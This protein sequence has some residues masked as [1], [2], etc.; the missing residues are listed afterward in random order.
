M[1]LFSNIKLKANL[2]KANP[3]VFLELKKKP[4]RAQF[5]D[6]VE[7]LRTSTT[8]EDIQTAYKFYEKLNYFD[9]RPQVFNYYNLIQAKAIEL[10]EEK[11]GPEIASFLLK[12]K[13][14][15]AKD[16]LVTLVDNYNLDN[17]PNK[18]KTDFI[19]SLDLSGIEKIAPYPEYIDIY[20]KRQEMSDETYKV[21][22]ESGIIDPKLDVI[23]FQEVTL[24]DRVVHGREDTSQSIPL[25]VN[26]LL[27][28]NDSKK[29]ILLNYISPNDKYEYLKRGFYQ[30]EPD[31]IAH[32]ENISY[33][34]YMDLKYNELPA[35]IREEQS[36]ENS[37][38]KRIKEKGREA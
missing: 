12:Q 31:A 18:S 10:S 38:F 27:L 8:L 1:N 16:L 30:N 23:R 5:A 3:Q 32:I 25:K 28:C 15:V 13:S 36:Q 22:L 19:N 2:K 9:V 20:G 4:S 33:N 21:L 26:P 7:F 37:G 34:E 14:I 6:A 29:D 24:R 11:N 35:S 17:L